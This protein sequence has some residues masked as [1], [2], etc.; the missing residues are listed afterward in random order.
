MKLHAIKLF[1]VS[2]AVSYQLFTNSFCIAQSKSE[3][4]KYARQIIDTLCSPGMHGRGYVNKGDS[5][6]ADYIKKEFQKLG[7]KPVGEKF[8]QRFG[9]PVN[10][11]PGKMYVK[12]DKQKLIPGKE[13]IVNYS[14]PAKF[15]KRMKILYGV[16]EKNEIGD[17]IDMKYCDYFW[18]ID[19]SFTFPKVQPR[20][21]DGCMWYSA[22][23]SSKLTKDFDKRHSDFA[24][25]GIDIV[26]L[27]K[28]FQD[29]PQKISLNIE[30]KY[31][32][33][34]QSQ[35]ILGYIKGTQFPDSFLVFSAHY[36][37][38]G[39]MGKDV[40][41]PGANDNASGCAMLLNLA[42]YFSEHPPKYS[43]A[44]FAFGG[45][46]VGLLGSRYYVEHP[47]FPLKQ[48]KFLVNLD[49]VGTGDEGIK[50][51]NATEHKTEFDVL[52]KINSEKDL[53]PSVQPRSKAANS[54]HYF[55]EEAGVKT[56]FIYTLGG[57]KAYH[58]IYDRPE[59]LPL[60]KFSELYNLLL[61]FSER[62]Q[63]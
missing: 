12:L 63:N 38:L 19:S 3:V 24:P 16:K 59:T 48:I 13:F 47:V 33:N 18:I 54:D 25:P 7:V 53:L 60:T 49:L 8:E 1:A 23:S 2:I 45:E 42:K 15:K 51:V 29:F 35:N 17:F 57:I 9:F 4:L 44:F 32:P 20:T 6:A 36:D 30:S 27:K 46:E 39:Q 26:I 50:V 43:V 31:F 55:F 40:Y 28:T 62:L 41:F 22:R 10:T 5:I 52:V 21:E 61:N 34:Y 14:H 37:H 58:D 56:F 11:F